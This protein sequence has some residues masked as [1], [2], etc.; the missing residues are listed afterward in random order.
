MT[1]PP[2]PILCFLSDA[3]RLFLPD[4]RV[5]LRE[6]ERESESDRDRERQ[7]E[8]TPTPSD[9]GKESTAE[10]CFNKSALIPPALTSSLPLLP[11]VEEQRDQKK[12]GWGG[13]TPPTAIADHTREEN[14]QGGNSEGCTVTARADAAR[15]SADRKQGCLGMRLA[16]SGAG[17][18]R[19]PGVHFHGIKSWP[20][21]PIVCHGPN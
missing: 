9:V 15:L 14:T 6:M 13:P 16:A 21:G 10:R 17:R 5:R 4:G 7:E 1:P 8:N 12:G 3:V 11:P 20:V 2:H 18:L 19:A